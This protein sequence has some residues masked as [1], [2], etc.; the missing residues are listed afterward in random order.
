MK[1][2]IRNPE[3]LEDTLQ[4]LSSMPK[5][6]L[7]KY[8]YNEQGSKIFQQ[9]MKMPEY[10]L[11]DC[12]H[13][14]FAI[15]KKQI[16]EA[17]SKENSPFDLIEL[18]AGDGTKTKILLHQLV[19]HSVNFNYCPI[20]IS[21][22]AND[23]LHKSL[24]QEIPS[25]EVTPQTG[26][27]FKIL[28]A[29]NGYASI[30]KVVLFLGSNVGNFSDNELHVFFTKLKDFT[31]RGDQVLIG[32][33]LKKSPHVIM[34]AYDDVHGHTRSFNLN[35]LSRLNTELNADFNLSQFEYYTEYSPETGAL[36]S[37]LV[38][39]ENQAVHIGALEKDFKFRKWEPL[40][41]ELSRKF[42]TETIENIAAKY[43]FRVVQQFTDRRNYFVDSLWARES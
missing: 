26:D 15:H 40:F 8:F 37:Y 24:K 43:G 9:I 2:I 35:H 42:D 31:H 41:M 25:I 4:G 22:I 12:E 6:L 16:I 30:R 17:F 33:D 34:N 32:F 21:Q 1:D 28:G 7:S 29:K 3:F 36:K 20:D 18:G 11:T 39:T 13:E 27:F 38:S 19:A 5:Y 23:E 10:Y 14:I